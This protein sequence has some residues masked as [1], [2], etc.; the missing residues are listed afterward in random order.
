VSKNHSWQLSDLYFHRKIRPIQGACFCDIS[1][2]EKVADGS[3]E[4]D[5]YQMAAMHF[6]SPLSLAVKGDNY[7]ESKHIN[8]HYCIHYYLCDCC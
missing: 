7:D 3:P 6:A 1:G 4:V 2:R 5:N 8:H